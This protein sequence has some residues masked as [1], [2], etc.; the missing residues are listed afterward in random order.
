MGR[1]VKAWTPAGSTLLS[2]A[3]APSPG[4][5]DGPRCPMTHR[6][7]P[8]EEADPSAPGPQRAARGQISWQ[9][10]HP[11][12]TGRCRPELPLALGRGRW[13][14]GRR[15][16]KASGNASAFSAPVQK[17][18]SPGP[19]STRQQPVRFG[20]R[21]GRQLSCGGHDC[22]PGKDKGERERHPFSRTRGRVDPGS[23]GA[24][25][26]CT[27]DWSLRAT[28]L[29]PQSSF[30]G[31]GKLGRARG[32]KPCAFGPPT[33]SQPPY[34]ARAVFLRAQDPIPAR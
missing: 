31:P 10:G 29:A 23:N 32:E 17:L 8:G 14:G 12:R 33:L 13:G 1:T 28:G 18:R 25:A 22:G 3:V 21:R 26:A 19:P 7:E 9:A 24:A 30:G 34:W 5:A 20:T 16:L 4:V 11:P 2:L 15:G 6:A 27:G